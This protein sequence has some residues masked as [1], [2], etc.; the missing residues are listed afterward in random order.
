MEFLYWLESIRNP[1]LDS[2]FSLITHFGSETLF[3]AIAI[4]VFWCFSKTNG[5]YL[6]TVGFF[7]T[8]TNQ[9]LKLLCRIPRPW[10]KDPSF[11]I[12]E[13]A[14][15][16]ATGYS[17]PSGHTQ[18]AVSVLGCPARTSKKLWTRIVCIT[19]ILLTGLS[20]M[21]LGVHTP[22]DVS[23]SLLVGTVLVFAFY[24]LFKKSEE[25]PFYMYAVLGVLSLCSLV[26]VLFANLYAWPAD[27]DAGNLSSG[28]KNGYLVLGC[29]IGMLLAYHIER[30]HIHFEVKAP[31]W[32]QTLKVILG[33][34]LV[35]AL[36]AGLKPV[37][38]AIC[39]G[40]AIATSLRYF[41]IVMFAACVWPLTFPWFQKGCP[42][43]KK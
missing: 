40:H 2:F 33:L 15:E 26:Y 12:V 18:N 16:G 4:I 21:Y 37:F 35:L 5:Y 14:R 39:G 38:T 29:S 30:K 25:N 41:T 43:G 24:P 3:L 31:W 10:V 22:Q 23:V 1:V 28:I 32:A 8:L 34:V 9:F 6:M 20:R 19:L 36:K 27:I 17:F 11:T 42:L 13:S 7:G